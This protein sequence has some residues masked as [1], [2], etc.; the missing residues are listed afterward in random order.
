[1]DCSEGHSSP[2]EMFKMNDRKEEH[3]TVSIELGEGKVE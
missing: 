1:M 2:V 3:L